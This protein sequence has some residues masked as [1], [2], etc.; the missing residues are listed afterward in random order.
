MG[1]VIPAG[2][3][4]ATA[5]LVANAEPELPEVLQ[6]DWVS[7]HRLPKARRLTQAPG[8]AI[9]EPKHELS[10]HAPEHG[11]GFFVSTTGGAESSAA[12]TD[13]SN[14]IIGRV[15]P[16]TPAPRQARPA[17]EVSPAG[18]YRVNRRNYSRPPNEAYDITVER[19]G[20]DG[21][22]ITNQG[23]TTYWERIGPLTYEKVTGARNGGPYE[24][25]QFHGGDETLVLSFNSQ[26]YMAYRR[27]AA[28]EQD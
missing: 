18:T 4:A 6:K 9:D 25:I 16:E 23:E 22:E 28:E 3:G 12:R 1:I 17:G 26:P 13:L 5:V 27:L 7:V 19:V 24:R 11:F 15:F 2:P 21:L 10:G 14:A 20:E 8:C